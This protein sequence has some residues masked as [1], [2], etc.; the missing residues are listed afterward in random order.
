MTECA[1]C[2]TYHAA[3]EPCMFTYTTGSARGTVV[4]AGQAVAAER[5]RCARIARQAYVDWF[6]LLQR[7]ASVAVET[8]MNRICEEIALAIERGAESVD[9][10]RFFVDP[11]GGYFADAG[12][13]DAA[14]ETS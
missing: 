2:H 4:V 14:E 6:D 11:H 12:P 8:G 9:R 3:G 13:E 5:T 10:E 7:Q 1:I